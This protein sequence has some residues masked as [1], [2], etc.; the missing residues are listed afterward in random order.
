MAIISRAAGV[1]A[2]LIPE[3]YSRGIIKNVTQNSAA[4]RLLSRRRMTRQIQRMSVLTAKP[5]AA[6]V[7]AGTAP[8]DSTDVGAKSVSRLTWAD[9]T[10]T[11]EPVAVIVIV[12]DHFY[13]DQAYDLDRKSTRLNSS[14]LGI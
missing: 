11:A 3:D 2:S 12:P 9:L 10:M 14:H 7:T 13:E 8:F 5:T 6:F 1:G 4:L